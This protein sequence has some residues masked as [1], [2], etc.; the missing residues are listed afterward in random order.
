MEKKKCD[1]LSRFFAGQIEGLLSGWKPGHGFLASRCQREQTGARCLEQL[2]HVQDLPSNAGGSRSH[3]NDAM[4]SAP[5]AAKRGAEP[6]V[7]LCS[8]RR[9]P[10]LLSWKSEQGCSW[11]AA[12][13][14]PRGPVPR[15][16]VSSG[17]GSFPPAVR[18]LQAGFYVLQGGCNFP[19]LP[20]PGHGP[21]LEGTSTV[22]RHKCT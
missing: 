17:P 18:D 15:Q 22:V 11:E 10:A 20:C 19:Y 16:G 8:L 14:S 9:P 3:A 2:F 13:P 1:R 4:Q 21:S 6:R 5:G 12:L 7:G